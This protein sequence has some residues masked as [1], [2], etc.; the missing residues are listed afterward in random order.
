MISDPSSDDGAGTKSGNGYIKDGS[1]GMVRVGGNPG[2][3]RWLVGNENVPA[4]GDVEG[5]VES[6]VDD[7]GDS[8]WMSC[9]I[10]V[11]I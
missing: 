5:I 3:P 11:T 2:Q 10:A 7:V 8:E 6:G 4:D 9:R 1:D